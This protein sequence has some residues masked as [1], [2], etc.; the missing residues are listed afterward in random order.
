MHWESAR[1]QVGSRARYG[2]HRNPATERI[3]ERSRLPL[4][5]R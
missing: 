4:E 5:S 3:I 1:N 2:V